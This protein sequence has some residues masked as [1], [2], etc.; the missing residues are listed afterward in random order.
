[1]ARSLYDH[2]EAIVA[3]LRP[4]MPER[5]EVASHHGPF[6]L[7]EIVRNSFPAPCVR[8]ALLGYTDDDAARTH[9]MADFAAYIIT[10]DGKAMS[11]DQMNLVLGGLL[12]AIYKT[13]ALITGTDARAPEKP[14]YRNRYSSPTGGAGL[15]L[16]VVTWS[17]WLAL[18]EAETN[19]AQPADFTLLHVDYDFAPADE[20]IDNQQDVTISQES[21]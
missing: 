9:G 5:V 17:Q 19:G 1:M 20:A 8:V 12:V 15:T 21:P 18:A 6:E 3:A 2:R 16:G 11:R 7:A 14:V 10:K 13:N 4:L